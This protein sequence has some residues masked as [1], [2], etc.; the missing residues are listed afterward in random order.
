MCICGAAA[1]EDPAHLRF[2]CSQSGHRSGSLP[3]RNFSER[4]I[5]TIGE[6]ELGWRSCEL[7]VIAITGTNGKTTT[8]EMIAQMLNACGQRTIAC[9]NIGK[10]LGRSRARKG[11]PRRP[12]RGSELV[13]ARN[14]PDV[15][16]LDRVWLNFA[17][18]HLDRYPLD[19]RSIARPSCVFS[20]TRR[21]TTSRWL[22]SPKSLPRL[23]AKI[24]TF[25]A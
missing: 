13:S 16:A 8:T 10:P 18:D 11:R 20:N 9:G 6:L 17:P 21:R 22:T 25:S 5:E 1:D 4:K 3:A 12:D 24:V 23:A 15:S 7:P 14:H 19:P 2:C